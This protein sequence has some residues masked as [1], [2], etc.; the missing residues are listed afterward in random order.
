M[1]WR[2]ICPALLGKD[3]LRSN[4]SG[5]EIQNGLIFPRGHTEHREIDR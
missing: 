2:V 5:S 3:L 4:K 1:V